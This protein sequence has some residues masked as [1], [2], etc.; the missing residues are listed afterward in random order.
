MAVQA[1]ISKI[2][3]LLA[4]PAREAMLVALADGR[5]LPAGK[6]GEAAGPSPQSGSRPLREMIGR[7]NVSGSAQ[8]PFPSF[9]GAKEQAGAAP[10]AV[11]KPAPGDPPRTP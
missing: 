4:D 2:A 5:A 10:G 1:G 3:A 8:G 6:L 9:R 7:R 11:R